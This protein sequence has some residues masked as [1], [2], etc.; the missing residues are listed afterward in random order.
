MT[1]SDRA[2]R[3][4][5]T[6]D[7]SKPTI[8]LTGHNQTSGKA[9]VHSTRPVPF[10]SFDDDKMS[11]G[12]VYTTQFPAKLDNEADIKT[13]DELLASNKLGLVN[14]GGT[15]C[16]MVDFDPGYQCLMHRT[17]SLDFGIVLDGTIEMILDS[18]ET[19]TLNKG[20]VA[21]Q[22]ATMH[23]WRNCSDKEPARMIFVLQDCQKP[24]VGGKSLGE[25]LGKG[26]Q[27]LPDS[28]NKT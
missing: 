18:G 14:G 21:V 4:S 27:G 5:R 23:A 19:A 9:I 13:H 7:L 12:V 8:F 11:M 20:D 10:A 25:D 16:R 3:G 1:D 22:R 28:S 17:Q 6:S 24:E 2:S 15:V 26:V